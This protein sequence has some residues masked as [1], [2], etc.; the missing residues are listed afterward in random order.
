MAA[1]LMQAV[2]SGRRKSG[3][4]LGWLFFVLVLGL[5]STRVASQGAVRFG[6]K[7]D[8]WWPD[9]VI[10]GKDARTRGSHPC[11]QSSRSQAS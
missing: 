4:G 11:S 9:F 7:R 2:G 1:A 5:F 10:G 3:L 8:W 6:Y